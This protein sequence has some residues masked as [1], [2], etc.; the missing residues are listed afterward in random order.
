MARG[1]AEME[2]SIVVDKGMQHTV[3][4]NASDASGKSH[5]EL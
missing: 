2:V 3:F 5:V 1:F 4:T